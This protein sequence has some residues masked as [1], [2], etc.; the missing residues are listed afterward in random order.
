MTSNASTPA[1]YSSTGNS[2]S[3]DLPPA[4]TSSVAWPP[5]FRV[6]TLQWEPDELGEG[7]FHATVD[8]GRDPEGETD[9]V[10]TLVEYRPSTPLPEHAPTVLWVHGMTDYFFQAHVAH[11]LAQRGIR[12]MGVD[13]RKCGR[14]WRP[15]QRWHHTLDLA[16]YDMEL[17]AALAAAGAHGP[18][19]VLA[20]STG[21]LITPLWLDRL[22]LQAQEDPAAAALLAPLAGVVLNSPWLGMMIP[23]WAEKMLRPAV[24]TLGKA[25]PNM[26]M[27]SGGDLSAYGQSIHSSAHGEWDFNL[28][29]KPLEGQPKTVGWLRAIIVGQDTIHS[30][31]VECPA[32]TM[33]LCSTSSWLNK[34]YS[35]ATDCA[36]AVL[37]VN[38]IV[39]WSPSLAATGDEVT[40]HQIPGARHDVFLSQHIARA[41]AF[42]R[43]DDF[44]DSLGL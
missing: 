19:V 27:R 6:D 11:H 23:N 15:G 12:T 26:P 14:S 18:V 30:G 4:A 22:R 1:P 44:L 25:R 36:D 2:S 42:A 34:P 5:Q 21:G 13:L 32:P 33:V 29:Y 43:L 39:S 16:Y 31:V 17:N 37:D 20:H 24:R 40:I 35:A 38:D 41:T 10:G 3:P 28:D 9:I 7:F 8:L